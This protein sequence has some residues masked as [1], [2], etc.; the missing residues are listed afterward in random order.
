[1][2]AAEAASAMTVTSR[3]VRVD[4][5][6]DRYT[7]RRGPDRSGDLL[8]ARNDAQSDK[9]T[10]QTNYET[11]SGQLSTLRP[12]SSLSNRGWRS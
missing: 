10:A 1:M 6:P 2:T 8:G 3:T 11:L 5:D 7:E 4:H 12:S 9:N